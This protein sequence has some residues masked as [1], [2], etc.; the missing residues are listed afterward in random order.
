MLLQREY[1][2]EIQYSWTGHRMPI[3]DRQ[4]LFLCLTFDFL[5]PVILL[6]L[7]KLLIRRWW[8]A[9][10]GT[11]VIMPVVACLV[12]FWVANYLAY[13]RV[14]TRGDTSIP[15]DLG[16][17][18]EE[19]IGYSGAVAAGYGFLFAIAGL[20]CSLPFVGLGVL[21]K[22]GYLQSAW[23]RISKRIS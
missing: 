15:D 3:F 19:Y 2:N 9:L 10:V 6:L 13:D 5:G 14:V 4:I 16:W 21:M 1:L 8:A 18:V 22:R 11:I 17:T 23:R 12:T 7:L 20:A